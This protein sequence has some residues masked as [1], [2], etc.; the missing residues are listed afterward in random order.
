MGRFWAAP[1]GVK[2]QHATFAAGSVNGW[3]GEVGRVGEDF[4]QT[5]WS[6]D[7]GQLRNGPLCFRRAEQLRGT[8]VF[9]FR[10]RKGCETFD[11]GGKSVV[12]QF[13]FSNCRFAPLAQS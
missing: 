9:S 1:C 5:E 4:Q 7:W 8:V 13:E 11:G 10:H 3:A 6:T 2:T 12:V